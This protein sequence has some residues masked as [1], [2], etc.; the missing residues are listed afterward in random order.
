MTPPKTGSD[1]A[2]TSSA[3]D[4]DPE[5]PPA[6]RVRALD[7]PEH[8][9]RNL[10]LIRDVIQRELDDELVLES[11]AEGVR[12]ILLPADDIELAH[13]NLDMALAFAGKGEKLRLQLI[14]ARSRKAEGE[15]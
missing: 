14:P 5:V 8:T 9:S 10:E 2:P 12:L 11:Q 4:L 7:P 1:I 13:A 3:A 15:K 6:A